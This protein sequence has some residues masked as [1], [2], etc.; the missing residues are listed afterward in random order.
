MRKEPDDG[1]EKVELRGE[2]FTKIFSTVD[3][4][5]LRSELDL[6]EQIEP[7]LTRFLESIEDVLR[8][9]S[10]ARVAFKQVLR[11]G[12]LNA[13]LATEEKENVKVFLISYFAISV[14]EN[15]Q[16]WEVM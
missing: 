11:D 4:L 15:D 8:S 1:A 3:L 13:L 9:S 16:G 6:G 7:P 14:T 2:I 5:L 10:D 12:G